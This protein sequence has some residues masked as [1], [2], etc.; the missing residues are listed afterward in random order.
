MNQPQRQSTFCLQFSLR[1]FLLALIPLG[2][3]FYGVREYLD[4]RPPNWQPYSHQR[5]KDELKLGRSVVICLSA[6]WDP[7]SMYGR[8]K[9]STAPIGRLFRRNNV[10]G[11]MADYTDPPNRSELQELIENHALKSIPAVVIYDQNSPDEPIVYSDLLSFDSVRLG[12]EALNLTPNV[13]Q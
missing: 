5:L 6:D 8:S 12:L 4:S 9:L 3:L 1:W 11:L 2:L 7:E 13:T 10:I